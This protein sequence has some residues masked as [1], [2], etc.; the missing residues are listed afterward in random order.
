[1]GKGV[2]VLILHKLS[3][4]LILARLAWH[5]DRKL[6]Q[7]QPRHT[8][9]VGVGVKWDPIGKVCKYLPVLCCFSL[10]GIRE[11]R[12]NFVLFLIL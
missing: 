3:V 2:C 1:M 5:S 8:T 12:N 4:V 6:L 10:P 7:F 11:I 9:F